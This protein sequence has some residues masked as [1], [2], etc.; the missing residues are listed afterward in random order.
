VSFLYRLIFLGDTTPDRITQIQQL[1]AKSLQAF[2]LNI[3]QEVELLINPEQITPNQ[4]IATAA[5]FF[6][7]EPNAT[8]H[9]STLLKN[10]IPILPIVSN[11][12]NVS[13]EIP[14]SL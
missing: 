2:E 1:L 12:K 11:L 5:I 4:L 8:Q 10:N 13:Q 7:N 6:G 3:D 14:S 9:L